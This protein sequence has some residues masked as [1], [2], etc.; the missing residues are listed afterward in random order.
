MLNSPFK[1]EIKG[2]ITLFGLADINIWNSKL[3][4]QTDTNDK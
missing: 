1:S 3:H 2:R 4:S